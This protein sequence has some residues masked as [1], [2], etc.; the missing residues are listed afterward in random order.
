MGLSFGVEAGL[1]EK[2][3]QRSSTLLLY[4]RV[5]LTLYDMMEV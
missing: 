1:A 4:P 3:V 2:Q 5:V